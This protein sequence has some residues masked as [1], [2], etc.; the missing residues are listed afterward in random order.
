MEEKILQAIK[1]LREKSKKR[2]FPQTVDLII[3]LK[4]FDIKRTENKFSEEVLLP[5]G[6]GEEADVVVFSNSLKD[7]DCNVLNSSD[8]ENLAKNKREAKKMARDTDFFLAEAPLMPVIG[9]SLGQLLA[10]RGKM[11]K[12]VSGDV[13]SIVK[14]LKKSVRIK[15]KDSPVIQ[16]MIG[17]EDMED[18]KISENI[19]TVLKFLETKLPKGRHNIKEVLLK[20][21]MSKPVKG[22]FYD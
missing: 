2:N 16:C 1:E 14:N 19:E 18:K 22:L 10:P 15:I 17:N 7:L 11:P 9:K 12:I 13:N 5:N 6:R 4:E 8:I 21:T 20:F 3:A